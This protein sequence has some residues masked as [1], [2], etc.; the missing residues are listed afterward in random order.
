MFNEQE[1]MEIIAFFDYFPIVVVAEYLFIKPKDVYRI[2]STLVDTGLYTQYKR[3][4]K[5]ELNVFKIDRH[6][7][8]IRER[9]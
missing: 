7:R 1:K 6:L 8:Y 3:L 4:A 9:I 2:Y 5:K